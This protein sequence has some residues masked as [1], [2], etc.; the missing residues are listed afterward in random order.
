MV[1]GQ[2]PFFFL[3]KAVDSFVC[4]CTVFFFRKAVDSFV[5][6][7]TVFFLGRRWTVSCAHA[8]FFFWGR[9]W[10]VSCGHATF[11]FW[12]AVDSFVC[13]CTVFLRK[14]VDSFVCACTVFL[15]QEGGGHAENFPK[16]CQ[17]QEV[18]ISK[19]YRMLEFRWRGGGDFG[20][21]SVLTNGK[22]PE[23]YGSNFA[24]DCTGARTVEW[25]GGGWERGDGY[26]RHFS[27]NWVCV[28]NLIIELRNFLRSH[29]SHYRELILLVVVTP[30]Q[31][32]SCVKNWQMHFRLGY[33]VTWMWL[34][35]TK[36]DQ[37][38]WQ[39]LGISHSYQCA[40]VCGHVCDK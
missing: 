15:F 38:V 23:R 21:D 27:C 36:R 26:Q 8:P 40:I 5:C 22:Y 31:Y 24:D 25:G 2:A 32:G 35:E 9:R 39:Q 20:P 4:A 14:A 1:W 33:E 29:I 34:S 13:A 11:F 3:R 37:L 16:G 19:T 7:C 28:C 18:Y 12:K 30:R 17:C 6:A 10:N